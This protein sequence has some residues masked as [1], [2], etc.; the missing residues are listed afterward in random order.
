MTGHGHRRTRTP[1]RSRPRGTGVAA[2]TSASAGAH[3]DVLYRDA[4]LC[5][6]DKPQGILVHGDGG[7]A[8]TLSELVARQLA[9]EGAVI[10]RPQA[11]QRLDV[12][13]SGIVLFSLDRDTQGAFDALFARRL[14]RKRYLAL[15][16]GSFPAGERVID[17]PLGRDRHDGRRMLVW[18]GGKPSTTRVRLLASQGQ[19]SR[20]RS[21][22][23]VEPLTG[24]RHRIRV[25]LSHLGFPIVGDRLYGAGAPGGLMLHALGLSL[26]H[27]L[28][29][30]PLDLSTPLPPCFVD[31]QPDLPELLGGLTGTA[32]S[33]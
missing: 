1:G 11:L 5:A 3:L 25:H 7:G 19:R 12:D 13:T 32:S 21:L 15:V 27:P 22:L 20:A 23:L 31:V 8:T 29:N 16:R 10:T 30:E 4:W 28:T 14:V 2:K 33:G 18:P 24:R 26:T 17:L 6:V 9:R